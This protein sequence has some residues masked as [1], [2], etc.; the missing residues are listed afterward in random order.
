MESFPP[1]FWVALG[2]VP[3][4]LGRFYLSQ[5]CARRWGTQFPWGTFTVNLS[6]SFGIG[7]AAAGFNHI[8]WPFPDLQLFIMTGFFGAYTTFSTYALELA[9][10]LKQKAY[11]QAV[12]YGLGSILLGGAGLK[13]GRWCVSLSLGL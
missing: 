1:L 13:L 12:L 8:S 9:G 4:A 11:R 10:L 3:G 5:F 2:A 7:A 6:G